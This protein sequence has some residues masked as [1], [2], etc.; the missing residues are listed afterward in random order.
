LWED[1]SSDRKIAILQIRAPVQKRLNSGFTDALFL[2][3]QQQAFKFVIYLVST[4]SALRTDQQIGGW[5]PSRIVLIR[6]ALNYDF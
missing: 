5:L 3:I 4:D 2:W 1:K 6:L